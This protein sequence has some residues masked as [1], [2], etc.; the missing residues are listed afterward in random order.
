MVEY[1]SSGCDSLLRWLGRKQA[2]N[3]LLP[4]FSFGIF[5]LA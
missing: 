3:F 4:L 2:K 1:L 5:I